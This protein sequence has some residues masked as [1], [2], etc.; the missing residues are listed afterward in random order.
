MNKERLFEYFKT[1]N[2]SKV[3][4]LLSLA[5]DT[6]DTNQR[7]DVFGKT[8][9]EIAPSSV[10]GKEILTTIEQFYKKSMD[11]YYYAPFDINSKNF[12]DIPEETDAWFDEISDYLED[13][14]RLTDQGEHEMA[15]QC[16]KLLYELID[17]MEDGDEIVFADEYGTWMITGDEKRFIESYLSS[18]AALSTPEEYANCTIPLIKR[19]SYQSFHNKVYTSAIKIAKGDQKVYLKT[20]VKKQKIR[21]RS[22]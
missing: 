8:A 14:S 11:G 2:Q 13:S 19:D 20:E 22:K 10:D 16:F 3:L 1:Q 5:F 9:K 15:V 18:L 7:H 21:T 17:K 12:S 6:M 4:E